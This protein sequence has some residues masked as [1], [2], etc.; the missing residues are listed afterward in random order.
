MQTATQY[1]NSILGWIK[2]DCSQQFEGSDCSSLFDIWKTTSTVFGPVLGK[3]CYNEDI[4]K[5]EWAQ[6][7]ATSLEVWST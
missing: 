1:A 2:Q 6:W 5:L 3:P 7:R 4:D